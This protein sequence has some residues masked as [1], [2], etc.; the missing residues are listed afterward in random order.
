MLQLLFLQLQSQF[1]IFFQNVSELLKLII[2]LSAQASEP[3]FT[4]P[5]SVAEGGTGSEDLGMGVLVG[6]G[7]TAITNSNLAPPSSAFVGTTDTQT[8]TNK[9]ISD[10]LFSLAGATPFYFVSTDGFGNFQTII[11]TSGIVAPIVGTL[12][13]TPIQISPPQS[14]IPS[15]AFTASYVKIGTNVTI[16]I[17]SNITG[18]PTSGDTTPVSQISFTSPLDSGNANLCPL[19]TMRGRMDAWLNGANQFGFFS[20]TTTGSGSSATSQLTIGLESGDWVYTAPGD[21]NGFI[22]FSFSFVSAV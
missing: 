8:L 7:T 6:N 11:S 14:W 21:A 22:G 18:V 4:T 2:I 10:G 17:P 16:Q 20:M 15:L 3:Q 9:T 5:I 19:Y 12:A 13:F 1:Y